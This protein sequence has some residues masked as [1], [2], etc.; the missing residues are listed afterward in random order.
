M[1]RCASLYVAPPLTG[2]PTPGASDGIQK[3][4]VEAHVD[5][6]LV[7]RLTRALRLLL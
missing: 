5:S 2:V 4:H 6:V 1:A 3:I 7:L